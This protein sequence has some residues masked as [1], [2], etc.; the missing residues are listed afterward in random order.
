MQTKNDIY[1]IVE[2]L[3][4]VVPSFYSVPVS[5]ISEAKKMDEMGILGAIVIQ[6]GD[7]KDHLIIFR[8]IE[9]K[10]SKLEIEYTAINKEK[11]NVESEDLDILVD[12]LVNYF[13]ALESLKELTNKE[14]EEAS[15]T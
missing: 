8:K 2:E 12:N 13:L 3:K 6:D 9:I 10:G 15:A 1:A 5:D 7:F 4:K 14:E 11:E